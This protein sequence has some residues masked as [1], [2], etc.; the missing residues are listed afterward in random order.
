MLQQYKKINN[1]TGWFVFAIASIVYLSTIEPTV[2]FWDCGE[3]ISTSYKLEVG[4]P[5]GAPLFALMSRF[6]TLFSFGHK[7]LA[8]K[9]INSMSALMSGLTILF[10][11]WTITHIARRIVLK[12]AKEIQK[13]HYFI[14][15]GSGIIG[16]LAYAFT[17]T[18]WFSAVE[19]EVYASSS[20][21]TAIVFWTI[22]K[23]EDE[24]DEPGANRWIILSAYLMGL[25]IGVHLL[26]IL[27][28]PAL[29]F[30]YYFKKYT[31]SRNGFLITLLISMIITAGVLW[32]IIPYFFK[33]AFQFE[34]IFTNGFGLPFNTGAIVYFLLVVGLIIFGLYYSHKKSKALLNTIVLGA[35]SYTHLR[36]HETHH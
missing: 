35:V 6:A 17:D 32:G 2:S 36:A 1:I 21:F 24:A 33:I 20:F 5:P 10:L 25:S 7:E 34:L 11:F 16:A 19:A 28:I 13:E 27:T 15:M 30:V 23:W 3:F 9:M 31:P 29:V 22:L 26:N 12:T 8:A 14:I 18:F 4:H